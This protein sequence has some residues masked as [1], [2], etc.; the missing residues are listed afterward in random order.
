MLAAGLLLAARADASQVLYGS[1]DE[2][3]DE[4]DVV[5]FGTVSRVEMGPDPLVPGRF[6]T[7]VEVSPHERLKGTQSG[8]VSFVVPGGTYGGYL[9]RVAGAPSFQRGDQVVVLLYRQPTGR[10]APLG[11]SLGVYV[12]QSG[13][14]AEPIATS[15]R[16]GLALRV[17]DPAGRLTRAPQA[18]H[19][20]TR[21]LKH[22]LAAIRR[23][24]EAG[25]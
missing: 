9:Y 17:R 24:V 14:L 10:L 3:T 8:S 5:V 13:P 18:M 4:A 15:D 22:L 2:L 23:R 11:L 7:R 6:R 16:R 20:D 12:V 19:V 1:L 25:R 21:P